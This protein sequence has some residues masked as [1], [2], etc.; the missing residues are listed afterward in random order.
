MTIWYS[1][2]WLLSR[3]QNIVLNSWLHDAV[4]WSVIMRNNYNPAHL[5]ESTLL[6]FRAFE[7]SF[8]SITRSELY[9]QK[10]IFDIFDDL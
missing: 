9:I 7:I 8:H 1:A 2:R 6:P 4:G 10:Y 5:R 3:Y